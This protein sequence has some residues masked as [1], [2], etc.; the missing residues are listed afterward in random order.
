VGSG[1]AVLVSVVDHGPVLTAGFVCLPSNFV[2][3]GANL[4]FPLVLV[5]RTQFP[6]R[7]GVLFESISDV[8]DV[9][10]VVTAGSLS[11]FRLDHVQALVIARISNS[12]CAGAVLAQAQT[13]V[14]LS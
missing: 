10:G 6:R 3:F 13:V 9:F 12:N 7:V 4:H 2:A 8:V 11:D 14:T 5:P 1:V